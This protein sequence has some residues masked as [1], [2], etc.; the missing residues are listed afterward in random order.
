MR[1]VNPSLVLLL[2][3][4]VSVSGRL[5]TISNKLPRIDSPYFSFWNDCFCRH[6]FLQ[7]PVL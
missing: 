3:V 2:Y 5:V 6:I 7:V 4:C 1:R